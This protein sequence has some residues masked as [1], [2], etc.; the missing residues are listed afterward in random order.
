MM[1]S[2]I[3]LFNNYR[4]LPCML[5]LWAGI[6]VWLG[7]VSTMHVNVI[8][9]YIGTV[10]RVGQCRIHRGNSVIYFFVTKHVPKTLR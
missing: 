3:S 1:K 10:V 9:L 7:R 2:C 5:L 4:R 8:E 6:F